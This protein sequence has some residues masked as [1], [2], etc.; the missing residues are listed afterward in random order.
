MKFLKRTLMFVLMLALI[1]PAFAGTTEAQA[2]SAPK[3]KVSKR[4]IYVGGSSVRSS[5]KSGKYTLKIANKPKKYSISDVKSSNEDAVTV[6]YLGSGKFELVAVGVGKS[7]ISANIYD[8]KNEVLKSLTCTVTTK[9]NAAA[10]TVTPAAPAELKPGETVSLKAVTYDIKGAN[11]D[12]T[13]YVKWKSSNEAVAKVSSS[14]VVRAMKAGTATITCYTVQTGSGTYAKFAKATATKEVTI[15]VANPDVPGITG[16]KQTTLSS[17]DVTLGTKFSTDVTAANFEL[18]Q[19]TTPVEIKSVEL[20]STKTVAT[21]KTA[22]ELN[23]LTTYTLTLKGTT[24]N[25][26]LSTD[27]KT[28]YG[29]PAKI[30][31]YSSIS[32]NRVISNVLSPIDFKIYSSTGIDI[33]PADTKSAAYQNH[34]R[35]ISFSFA[36]SNEMAFF[37]GNGLFI[38]GTGTKDVIATYTLNGIVRAVSAKTR[39]T[40]VDEAATIVFDK[41]IITDSANRGEYLDWDKGSCTI[42]LSDMSG[43]R[44]VVRCKNYKGE[45][46]YSDSTDSPIRIES[47]SFHNSV[48]DPDCSVTPYGV[49]TDTFKIFYN[50]IEIKKGCVL[51]VTAARAAKNIVFKNEE[52][53]TSLLSLSN[54]YGVGE[55][56]IKVSVTD[57]SGR[58]IPVSGMAGGDAAAISIVYAGNAYSAPLV[59]VRAINQNE[60]ALDFDATSVPAGTY[61]FKVSFDDYMYGSTSAILN[62]SVQQPNAALASSYKVE[63]IGNTDVSLSGNLSALPSLEVKLFEL[64]GGIK[65][66]EVYTVLH[67]SA[68]VGANEFYYRLI[69]PTGQAITTGVYYNTIQLVS[70]AAGKLTKFAAGKYTVSVFRKTASGSVPMCSTTFTVTDTPSKFTVKQIAATTST[71]LSQSMTVGELQYIL[72]QCFEITVDGQPIDVTGVSFPGCISRS[73]A[74]YFNSIKYSD[75]V[76]IGGNT[77][78][79]DRVIPIM[80]SVSYKAG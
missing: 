48:I 14:G 34:L 64:K 3:F 77:Y 55:G 53:V 47:E 72:Q 39:F 41:A 70:S 33:T 66:Q 8:K 16:I 52:T 25:V 43:F 4:T 79:I 60:A 71:A 18:K 45:Y 27:L 65:Y 80:K 24:A 69:G 32:G 13:D 21:V 9:K 5:Y 15:K 54:A 68:G 56:S 73:N 35:N 37:S 11:G 46:I 67:E 78:T 51:T 50:S 76:V 6:K 74:V 23:D 61:A 49:G 28:N 12:C 17:F 36:D 58:S 1:I 57:Q 40:A 44:V 75:N 7:T 59:S 2:A 19:G 26:G 10:I 30:E 29:V 20:D 62:V 63:V 38:Y 42:S 31:I 22:V